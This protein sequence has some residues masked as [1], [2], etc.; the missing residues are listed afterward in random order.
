MKP[1]FPLWVPEHLP[2]KKSNCRFGESMKIARELG[3]KR[4]EGAAI[5]CMAALARLEGDEERATSLYMESLTLRQ[6]LGDRQG[7]AMEQLNLG[8]MAFHKG[9]D[10][11]AGRLFAES[12]RS[13]HERGD[14]YIMPPNLVGLAGIAMKSGDPARAARLLGSADACLESAGLVLDP[15]DALEYDRIAGAVRDKLGSDAMKVMLNE[16]RAMKID[17]AIG[18]ALEAMGKT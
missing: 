5:H 1:E 11:S 10:D 15:D 18:Y 14:K 9:D 13:S 2:L 17:H 4:S 3:D 12:L 6:E 16:G 8:F 7:V